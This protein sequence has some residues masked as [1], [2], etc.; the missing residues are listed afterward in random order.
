MLDASKAFD[1][2]NY[3]RL[4]TLLRNK[5]LCPLYCRFP[6]VLYTNQQLFVKWNNTFCSL[7]CV[8]NGVKQGGVLSPILFNMYSDVLLLNFKKSGFGCH[9]GNEF[10]SCFAY[11]DDIVLLSPTCHGINKMLDI[12]D[13][14]IHLYSLTFNKD[15]T[16]V[17]IF[18]DK[19]D[20][21]SFL[22]CN[23]CT[24]VSKY[25]KHLGTLIGRNVNKLNI[26][27]SVSELTCLSNDMCS[28]FKGVQF[29]IKYQLFKT[30]CMPLYGSVLWHFSNAV[31]T[32]LYSTWLV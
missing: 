29:D 11:A 13:K 2:V 5:G 32:L 10:M 25:E 18:N 17:F 26:V 28:V 4:F 15:K 21:Q 19:H 1:H 8:S 6:I 30:L 3:I 31:L 22:L 14:Y 23:N 27:N 24:N 16:K 7:F 20:A 12:C 9:I